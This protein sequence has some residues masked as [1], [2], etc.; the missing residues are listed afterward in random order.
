MQ[1]ILPWRVIMEL[2]IK[3]IVKNNLAHMLYYR[4]QHIYYSI[5]VDGVEYSFP[6][7]LDDIQDATLNKV[8]KAMMLMRYI[9]KAL[10]DGSFVKYL[11]GK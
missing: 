1:I 5:N 8:E 4:H 2:S 10:A 6:V 9:R 7:P 3:N 11:G